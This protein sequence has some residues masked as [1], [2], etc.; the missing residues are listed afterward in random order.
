MARPVKLIMILLVMLANVPLMAIT[1]PESGGFPAGFWDEILSGRDSV[2]YGD[3]GWVQRMGQRRLIREQIA[4]GRTTLAAL[5][6]AQFVLPVILGRY[7]DASVTHNAAEFTALL[8]GENPTGSLSDYYDEISYGQF[9][10]T[11]KVYGWFDLDNPQSY[12]DGGDNGQGSDFPTNRSGF[13]RDAVAAADDSVDFSLYDNDGPDGNPNSGDDDGYVDGVYVVYPGLGS[14]QTTYGDPDNLWPASSTLGSNEF[15]TNDISYNGGFIKVNAWAIAPEIYGRSGGVREIQPI[16]VFAH[17]FG[18]VLGLPDLYDRTG[19]LEGPDFD[20]SEGL[21]NWCLMAGGSYGG[22]GEHAASPTH[23]SAWCK[24]IMGWVTPVT[25]EQ[26]GQYSITQA[27]TADNV[28]RLWADDH[29]LS[30][31]FLVENRQQVG[32]DEFIEGPGLLI[33]HVDEIRWYGEARFSSGV[34][35]DDESFKLVDIEA[36]DGFTD[37]DDNVNP[38]DDGDPWPGSSGNRTFNGN[39]T[40]SSRDYEGNSTGVSIENISDPGETMSAYFRPAVEQGYGIAYDE[41]GIS[42]WGWGPGTGE[43]YW[44]GVLFTAGDS[45][46]LEALDIGFRE[47]DNTY[48]VEIYSSLTSPLFNGWTPSGL[49]AVYDDSIETSG[50]HTIQLPEPVQLGAGQDFFVSLLIYNQAYSVSYDHYGEHSGRSYTSSDGV[51]FYDGIST[52]DAG[53]DINIRARVRT[54]NPQAAPLPALSAAEIDFG[55]VNTGSSSSRAF[56][57]YNNG[58]AELS[59]SISLSGSPA[60]S[61]S[62]SAAAVAPGDSQEV[63]V[64][65]APTADGSY[66]GTVT[67]TGADT[68]LTVAL[69][70][71]AATLSVFKNSIGDETFTETT[72]TYELWVELNPVID[73]P[74]VEIVYSLDG[75]TFSGGVECVLVDGRYVGSLPAQPLNSTILYYFFVSGDGE[76]S[77]SLPAGAPLDSYTLTVALNKPGDLD[78]DWRVSIFDVLEVLGALGD[79]EAAATH[80]VDS[81]GDVDIF[82]LLEVLRLM[83]RD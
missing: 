3:P 56:S 53:G 10:L 16:G 26:E 24:L 33:Y 60:F 38:G 14:N 18:H 34:N 62:P 39:S 29:R 66:D 35:N 49:L 48:T 82:D 71:S 76:E 47:D 1:P 12:Y 50:W 17:E 54:F 83:G 5:D 7:S 42:G 43:D 80:D 77:Y 40:P 70:G 6:Q 8:F 61:V 27:E 22:D 9:R 30:S 19:D 58:D 74:L 51:F 52:S 2:R 25:V 36:A 78:G 64:T 55:A 57:L 81:D 79:P 68:S 4:A 67:V 63:T 44:A 31:Y 41:Q 46:S 21:G 13:V 23:M 11:G 37:M 75:E 69:S 65:F 32:F 45:G 20:D 15:T 72:G 28:Y 73:N 59:A